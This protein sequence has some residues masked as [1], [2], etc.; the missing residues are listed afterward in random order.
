MNSI[1]P[2]LWGGLSLTVHDMMVSDGETEAHLSGHPQWPRLLAAL[3]TLE[4]SKNVRQLQEAV[5]DWMETKEV[6]FP[7]DCLYL[8]SPLLDSIAY[9]FGPHLIV[10]NDG[11][12]AMERRVLGRAI[13]ANQTALVRFL[14]P[15][16]KRTWRV[17][18]KRSIR[19]AHRPLVDPEIVSLIW[20]HFHIHTQIGLEEYRNRLVT[21]LVEAHALTA[22]KWVKSKGAP[23]RSAHY[24]SDWVIRH[25]GNLELL[26]WLYA[27]RGDVEPLVCGFDGCDGSYLLRLC[28]DHWLWEC[29]EFYYQQGH[30]LPQVGSG[31]HSNPLNLLR[32]TVQAYR[33]P[34]F[35]TKYIDLMGFT[36]DPTQARALDRIIELCVLHHM[37]SLLTWLLAREDVCNALRQGQMDPFHRPL[38]AALHA[39]IL[40]KDEASARLLLQ[41]GAQVNASQWHCYGGYERLVERLV[42]RLDALLLGMKK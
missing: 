36:F 24:L 42:E 30:R 16:Y 40:E 33:D 15:R 19:T 23:I 11:P 4:E 12:L 17:A 34:V 22:L 5:V 9:T 7:L 1:T 38:S 26:Q 10:P 8:G 20:D 13:R 29:F 21:Y 6:D 31:F 37:P 39:A 41:A 14:L 25:G 27:T 32:V 18:L 35:T 28:F 2:T 3:R